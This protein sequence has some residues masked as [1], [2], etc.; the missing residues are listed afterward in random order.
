VQGNSS[1]QTVPTAAIRNGDFSATST[2]IYDPATGNPSTGTGR[3]PFPNN[4]IP[5]GRISPIVKKLIALVPLPNTNTFGTDT[6][7]YFVNTPTTYRLQKIDTK[8]NWDASSKLRLVGRYSTYPYSSTQVPVFGEQLGG[9][10][11]RPVSMATPMQPP[12][13]LPIL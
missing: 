6:N 2:T 12:L 10:N 11:T 3:T 9:S 1:F 8:F 5:A 4:I 13:A 7:N